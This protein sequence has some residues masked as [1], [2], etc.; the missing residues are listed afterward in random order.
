[1]GFNLK[2]LCTPAFLYFILSFIPLVLIA[3]YN[4]SDKEK[5]CLGNFE[6]YV[7]SN[8][9]IFIFNSIYILFWT[10]LLDLL[11]KN[12]WVFSSWVLF[13]FPL[14]LT[15]LFYAFIFIFFTMNKNTEK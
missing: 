6:C 1:M 11:C 2:D 8:L 14:I 13:L 12:G 15:F 4:Y 3:I 7:G 5:L 10:Y 9:S